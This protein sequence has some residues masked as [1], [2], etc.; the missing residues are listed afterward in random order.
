MTK[1][2]TPQPG[3]AAFSLEQQVEIKKAE[4]FMTEY[5]L[6]VAKYGYDFT[7]Q[8]QNVLVKIQ[9][10]P[11]VNSNLNPLNIPGLNKPTK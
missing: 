5:R 8:I 2:P 4:D 9:P 10:Q 11:N 3:R 7:P 6:L 1:T